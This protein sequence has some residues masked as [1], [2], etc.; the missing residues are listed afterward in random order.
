MLTGIERYIYIYY[1][2]YLVVS[3]VYHVV[4]ILSGLHSVLL[5]I[6]VCVCGHIDIELF[7][8]FEVAVLFWCIGFESGVAYFI[9]FNAVDLSL[10]SIDP[11]LSQEVLNVVAQALKVCLH[12]GM[13]FVLKGSCLL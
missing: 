7:F 10:P 11:Y 8:T 4:D 13:M 1:N 9:M 5:Y 12:A 3:S 2:M 6:H